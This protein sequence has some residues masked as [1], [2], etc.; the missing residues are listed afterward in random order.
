MF[1]VEHS[2]KYRWVPFLSERF[3]LTGSVFAVWQA[4]GVS[5]RDVKRQSS[6]HAG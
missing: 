3:V 4:V 6:K 5:R 2:L 1:R